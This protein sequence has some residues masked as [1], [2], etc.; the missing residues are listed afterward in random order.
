DS[1][2]FVTRDYRISEFYNWNLSV[3][4]EIRGDLMVEVAYAGSKGNKLAGPAI[5]LNAL[6]PEYLSLGDALRE[7]VP[8]P[9]FGK[10]ATGTLST[11]TVERQ[12]LLRAFPQ[13]VSVAQ[14]GI[15]DYFSNYHSFLLTVQKRLSAGFT[16]SGAYTV[17][18]LIDNAPGNG[19]AGG[20]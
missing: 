20:S 18:K 19:E 15:H 9:F 7:R 10:I 16:I 13:F 3:Q 4:R 2:T 12:Q 6:R 11:A 17:S 5:D 1:G 8:N 14:Q